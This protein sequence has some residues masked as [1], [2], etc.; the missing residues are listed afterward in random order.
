MT[1][2]ERALVETAEAPWWAATFWGAASEA[3]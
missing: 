3:L 1:A 2:A